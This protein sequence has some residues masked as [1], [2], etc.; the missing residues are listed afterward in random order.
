MVELRRTERF[1]R[2]VD[3]LRDVG[4]RAPIQARIERLAPAIQAT[5]HRLAKECTS[6]GSTLVRGTACISPDEAA[7]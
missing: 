2:W 4:G 3:A 7:R 6:C 1:A 5:S